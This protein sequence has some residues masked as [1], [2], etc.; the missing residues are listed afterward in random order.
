MKIVRRRLTIV[1][2]ALLSIGVVMIYSASAIYALKFF[3]DSAYFLKRHLIYLCIGVAAAL[4]I[5]ATNYRILQK[6]AKPLMI[7]SLLLLILVLF[8][9]LGK[10]AGG[11]RRWIDLGV[12]TFQPS[13][14]VQL[15]IV[16]YAADFISRKKRNVKKPISEFMPF[17]II[18]VLSS[19]LI[20]LQ[21]DLG[22]TV[23]IAAVSGIMLFYAGIPMTYFVSLLLISIPLLYLAI[24]SVPYRRLRMISFLN[25][26][27]DP[28]GSG[29]QLIQSQIALGSGGIFG[30][31]LGQSKQKLF[32]LPA[33]HTDFIFSI[34]GEETGILG[35]LVVMGLFILFV[36][37]VMRI[38]IRCKDNF[39]R[40]LALGLSVSIALKAAINMAVSCGMLP[41]KGLP[42][43]FISYGGTALVIDLVAV[44]I[45]L[46]ISSRS[47]AHK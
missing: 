22:T 24:F 13:V 2:L 29:F 9:S 8:P 44:G 17:F 21:P 31:G 30:L 14:F 26:W 35:S 47:G 37:L 33:A 45:I 16:L 7:F 25:P 42:L 39:G 36:W 6:Y 5:M 41:T 38:V 34:I 11:A 43:P 1:V 32:Y 15:C 18:L 10:E 3:N 40:L 12:V 27:A 4:I 23:V 28:Q 20:L 19:L 46:N